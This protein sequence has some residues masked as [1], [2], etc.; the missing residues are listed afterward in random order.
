MSVRPL[1]I[2]SV[3]LAY[4]VGCSGSIGAPDPQASKGDAAPSVLADGGASDDT[5]DPSLVVAD[6]GGVGEEGSGDIDAGVVVDAAPAAD[7]GA[8]PP[9]PP[10]PPVVD[11][12]GSPGVAGASLL[13]AE[14]ARELKTMVTSTYQHTTTVDEGK[15]VFDY[16]CSGFVDYALSVALSDALTTVKDATTARPLAKDFETFFVSIASSSSSMGRWHRVVRALDLTPGDVV[17]WLKPADV[18]SSNTG[19]V[20]IVRALPSKNPARSDEVLVPITDST[21]TPHGPSDSRT[22]AGA[23]GLGTGTIGLIVDASGAPVSYRWTG[24]Y[25]TKIESTSIA[26][27]HVQ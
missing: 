19:H 20:M 27:G 12:G 4:L 16:D 26:L 10:P 15:G 22:A 9:P 23:T 2:A 8:P 14:A 6:P 1:G 24:G 13:A 25:S 18:T 21:S 17:A 5:T 11:A 7:S 3:L